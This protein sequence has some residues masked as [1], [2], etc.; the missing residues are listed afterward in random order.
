MI[1]EETADQDYTKGGDD[2]GYYDDDDYH[3]TLVERENNYWVRGWTKPY[4]LMMS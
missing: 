3:E 2:Q 4:V 1:P